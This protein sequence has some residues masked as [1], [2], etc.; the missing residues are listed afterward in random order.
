MVG[1]GPLIIAA[2]TIGAAFVSPLLI[3]PGAIA[4]LACVYFVG[5]AKATSA[6]R[7]AGMQVEALPPTIRGDLDEVTTA[8]DEIGEMIRTAPSDSQ[9]LFVG[10]TAE[11]DDVRESVGELAQA[12]GNLHNYLA[13]TANDDPAPPDRERLMEMLAQYRGSMRE[14]AESTQGL[15]AMVA[16]MAAGRA[17]DTD[18]EDAPVQ[19][20]DEMKASVMALE[21]VM[22]TSTMLQ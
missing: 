20:M 19:K 21:E 7:R 11:A 1:P 17:L 16:R 5:R 12:A 13:W 6:T 14:L 9:I 3:A 22:S 8:L 15:R 18:R 4:W 2:V 10:I